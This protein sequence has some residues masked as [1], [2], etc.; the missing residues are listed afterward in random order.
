MSDLQ[1][2]VPAGARYRAR[3]GPGG[4]VVIPAALRRSL[5]IET[6]DEVILYLEDGELRLYTYPVAVE[7]AQ[8]LIRKHIP[9]SMNLA[10][11]LLADRRREAARE[12]AEAA[13]WR[14][15]VR[16]SKAAE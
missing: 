7:R 6:G 4:R 10:D 14:N 1:K 9:E 3:V 16:A 15:R 11:E 2:Y 13:E 8:A 12:E 5:K